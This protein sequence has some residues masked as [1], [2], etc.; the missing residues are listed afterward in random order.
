MLALLLAFATAVVGCAPIPL[1]QR[2]TWHSA[3]ANVSVTRIVH[4]SL[5]VEIGNTRLLIDPW[6]HSGF[7]VRQREPLGLT[8]DRLPPVS[9]ILE[10]HAHR[11]HFDPQALRRL[12]ATT[13][14]I[15]GPRELAPRLGALGFEEV[16]GL[17]WWQT[18]RI[19]DVWVTAVPAR[20][21]VVENGYVLEADGVRLYVAGD[22]RPF[23]EVARIAE[24]FPDL[25]VALLPVGGERF[26][27]L[28]REMTPREAAEAAAA[29][30]ATRV[31]PIGY[32]KAGTPVVWHARHPLGAFVDACAE[33]GIGRDRIV[34]LAPGESWHLYKE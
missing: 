21:A 28:P 24:R 11:D 17:T 18:T 9:A 15:V 10:T 33:H 25:D 23:P 8:P 13:P 32:G 4:A 26:L 3:D 20:H 19:G 14:R 7:A 27:G 5:L 22:T 31:I 16:T 12:A 1:A 30:G 34:I 6:F 29:L 2:S